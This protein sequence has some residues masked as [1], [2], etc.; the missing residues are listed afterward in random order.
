MPSKGVEIITKDRKFQKYIKKKDYITEKNCSLWAV[1][2]ISFVN[3][4]YVVSNLN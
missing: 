4:I 2:G 1:K 3:N